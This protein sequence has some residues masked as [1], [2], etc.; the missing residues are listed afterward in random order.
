MD[1]PLHS[2]VSNDP[3]GTISILRCSRWFLRLKDNQYFHET[4]LRITNNDVS[5][6]HV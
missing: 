6:S 3:V 4:H 2:Q 5:K 1:P